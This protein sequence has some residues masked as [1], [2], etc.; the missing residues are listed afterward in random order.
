MNLTLSLSIKVFEFKFEFSVPFFK[1]YFLL[2]I[3]RHLQLGHL[4][5]FPVES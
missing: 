2:D 4:A 3:F 5:A 1:I